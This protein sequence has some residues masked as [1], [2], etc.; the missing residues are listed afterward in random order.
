MAIAL[1][2]IS[3]S[4]K[5][6]LVRELG[7]IRKF[8]P[9]ANGAGKLTLVKNIREIRAKLSIF[10][11]PDAAMVNIDIADVD[12]TYK[13]MIDYLEN[14]IKQLPAALADSERVLAA[15]IGRFFYNMSSNKDEILGNENYKKFQSMVGGR[16]D[17]G[18]GQKKVFDHFKSLGDVFE[19]DAEKVKI[20]TQEIS[21][22]SS[23]TP[24]DPPEIAEKKRQ[25]QEVYN[26]L[27]DK[28]SSLYE[29]R[30][31]AKFSNDPFAVDKIKK[32][33]DSLFVAFD[34]IR[35][36]LKKLDRIKYEKKQERIE[37]LKKQ[38]APVGN[39]FISTLLD[40]SKVTQE[41]A[42]SWAGAQKITKSALTRL[43]KLGYAEVDI[44]RD[45]AEFYRITGG[46][47]RQIIIDNNGSRRANTNG[48]G[49]VE[50]T[51]IYPDS[52]FNKTVLWHEMAHHLEADPIAK[53]A[54]NGFLVKRRKDS[55]VYSL[56]SLT[57]NRGYRSN[58]VAYADDFIN[59]Y[60]GKVYRDE[61][62][63]VWSM[64]VQ[65]LSNP[66][67]AAL[68]LA[69]D[70]EMAA[71]MAGYL[72]AD[73]T[74]AMKALQSIQDHA[75]DK[76]EAQRDNEQKQ[77]EDAIA[78][79]A[80]GVKF[81]ND[82]WF[83][84]LND[85]DRAIVTRHSVPAKSNAEFIGSWNGYRV[86]Y[87]KFKSRKSKRISKGYQVVYSPES[88]G[89][90][91]INSG[92]FHEE[93]DAV[94]AALMVTSEVFGHDVYRASYR[95]FAHYAH[96]EEMIRNADIVLAHKETKDSQ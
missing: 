26:D 71:L 3:G 94:K 8:L 25:T 37:E 10:S 77:Y 76:V 54:S 58:E 27:R 24:S 89:I 78:K 50:D 42:E 17:S 69:K 48:I 21:N 45:M 36:E 61:T 82:G 9:T 1:D 5:L 68:M 51:V 52:R 56:R 83:D 93:I 43:K 81:V 90:H 4:E 7:K 39:E 14:G 47:L 16:Y 23:T 55:K 41:Q 19:Y 2:N 59:P 49:S 11:K 79:L 72:Q 15:K 57:G 35:T 73:L 22:I 38:I 70:P 88:S 12:A 85:E 30:F 28:L 91:H 96:K 53:D 63:E 80:R 33:Y 20:I 34:E 18:Y 32:T 67:D 92:A 62:T 64:G 95:L 6:K 87:G 31:E 29:R 60:I 13:S 66:Q 46:K 40:V 74:P 84:A 75:K 44:R 65:Y 86:F